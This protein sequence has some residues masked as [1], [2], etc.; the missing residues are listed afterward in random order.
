LIVLPLIVGALIALVTELL[1]ALG[2]IAPVPVAATW[3]LLGGVA[4]VWHRQRGGRLLPARGAPLTLRDLSGSWVVVAVFL[5]VTFLLGLAS[6]PNS[7]DALTYHLPRVEHWV[8]Q[9]HL[10]FWPTSVDRQLWMSPWPGY[11]VLQLRLLTGG[12]QLAFLPSWLAYLGCILLTARLVRQLGGDATQAGFGALAMATV[13]IAVHQASAVQ[14]DVIAGFWIL[15]VIALVI[16]AWREPRASA[17]WR[18]TLALASAAALALVSKG[19]AAIAIAP[20]LVL[21]VIAA[22]RHGGLAA[23]VR[24]LLVGTL[25]ALVL[26]GPLLARN[27][28]TFSSPM[29][30][31]WTLGMLRLEPFT[32]NGAAGNLAANLSLH[33]GLPWSAW[34]ETVGKAVWWLNETVLRANPAEQFRHYDGFRVN[35]FSTHESEAGMPVHLSLLVGAVVSLAWSRNRAALAP[36]LPF[37]LAGAAAFLLF[38]L[39]LRWQPYGARLQLA[40]LVWLPGLLPFLVRGRRL[41]PPVAGLL[42]L[43]AAPALLFGTPRSLLGT[44]S[45]LLTTRSEQFAME[46]PEHFAAA[47]RAVLEAGTR[48]CR[49]LGIFGGWDFPEYF[50]TALTSREQVALRWEHFISLRPPARPTDAGPPAEVCLVFLADMIP[51]LDMSWLETDFRLLWVD[52]PFAVLLRAP[53]GGG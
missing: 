46:R 20:F 37:L 18:H 31:E 28:A 17:E 1:G 53:G 47:E 51:G 29:G 50:L 2:W 25:A 33:A 4:L 48:R 11:V 36:F 38:I 42:V 21:Y 9:G 13:P 52:P 7:W 44:D 45:V 41:R 32:L 35:G 49:N 40:S 22:F 10:G 43:C 27:A 3:L 16:E 15:C 24:P 6:A 19:T 39:V 23:W 14:T 26:N 12:D 30:A 34:N 8:E 5:A